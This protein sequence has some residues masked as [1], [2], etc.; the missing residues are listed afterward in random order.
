[1]GLILRWFDHDG[2]RHRAYLRSE[3]ERA[4]I[5]ASADRDRRPRQSGTRRLVL[6]AQDWAVELPA[7]DGRGIE[8]FSV[9]ELRMLVENA[10][11]EPV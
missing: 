10:R 5:A 11:T 6:A 1:M 3:E 8:D 9:D 2:V 7:D 4:G